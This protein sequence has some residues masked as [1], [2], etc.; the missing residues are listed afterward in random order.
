MTE[1]VGRDQVGFAGHDPL[2]VVVARRAQS[3]IQVEREAAL[4]VLCVI[5]LQVH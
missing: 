3:R 4:K 2:A 1:F 5:Q